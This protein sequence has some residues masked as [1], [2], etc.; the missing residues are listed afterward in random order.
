MAEALVDHRTDPR[1]KQLL[2]QILQKRAGITEEM[3]DQLVKA[4]GEVVYVSTKISAPTIAEVEKNLAMGR[5][6]AAQLYRA[7][8]V[9]LVPHT[10][11]GWM[12]RRV[13]GADWIDF[14]QI[15]VALVRVADSIYI[16]EGDQGSL[17]SRLE[18]YLAIRWGK[19]VYEQGN[20]D[21]DPLIN[22]ALRPVYSPLRALQF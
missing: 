5:S 16:A 21:S 20:P 2:A 10:N 7:G 12:D 8:F 3:V 19:R 22:P 1:F 6:L 13:G 9:P 4:E 11:N 18:K 15:D 14:M 17:G